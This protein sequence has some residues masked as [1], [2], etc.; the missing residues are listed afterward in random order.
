MDPTGAK[1]V[2][3]YSYCR[4][5][6]PP[7][8]VVVSPCSRATNPL[9][10][11]GRHGRDAGPSP[12]VVNGRRQGPI[13]VSVEMWRVLFLW[14]AIPG[15]G[16]CAIPINIS[17]RPDSRLSAGYFM[18]VLRVPYLM[19][20]ITLCEMSDT[21]DSTELLWHTREETT[22]C[23]IADGRDSYSSNKRPSMQF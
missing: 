5:G 7:S 4:A 19:F 12:A 8:T 11:P 20:S 15:A 1:H 6:R 2:E 13:V 23:L 17:A 3:P 21:S 14:S 18:G 9:F 10:H 16:V 22:A